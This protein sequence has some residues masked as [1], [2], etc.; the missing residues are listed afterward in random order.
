M[1]SFSDAY[2]KTISVHRVGN[3][4]L[5]EY[6]ALSAAPMEPKDELLK[7]L[8][9]QYFLSPFEKV[10]DLYRFYQVNN[11]LGLNTIFHAADAIFTDPSTFHEV[12]Q[13]IARFLFETTD[14]PKIRSGELY[15]VSFK[16]IQLKYLIKLLSP[17]HF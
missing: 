6:F 9:T 15:A 16:D 10:N 13:D 17:L 11:D 1:I 12:S 14:H 4:M 3:K 7:Q 8:L 5:D 2:I